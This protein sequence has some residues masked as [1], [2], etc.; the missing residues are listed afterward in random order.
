MQM[1][2]RVVSGELVSSRKQFDFLNQLND[3]TC[4]GVEEVTILYERPDCPDT[5]FVVE[6]GVRFPGLCVEEESQD[7]ADDECG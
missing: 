2:G 7:Q 5:A 6:P 4:L 3:A 1:T